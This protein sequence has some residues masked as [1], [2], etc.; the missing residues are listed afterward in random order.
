M[1]L[2]YDGQERERA[3]SCSLPAPSVTDV[4]DRPWHRLP[5]TPHELSGRG[6]HE[7]SLLVDRRWPVAGNPFTVQA[8]EAVFVSVET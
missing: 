3:L 2:E 4:A 7:H 5:V 8:S 1:T 6:H